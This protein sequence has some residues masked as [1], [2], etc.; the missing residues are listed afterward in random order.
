MSG[1][2]LQ[3]EERK[4]GVNSRIS[5]NGPLHWGKYITLF[6]SI[7]NVKHFLLNLSYKD[8]VYLSTKSQGPFLKHIIVDI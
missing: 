8:H 3:Q 6:S 4:N 1:V 7:L 5:M 2:G